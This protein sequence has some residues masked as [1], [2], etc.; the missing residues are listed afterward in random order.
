MGLLPISLNLETRHLN[1]CITICPVWFPDFSPSA[2][3]VAVDYLWSTTLV[4]C[5]DLGSLAFSLG[6]GGVV[7]S[8]PYMQVRKG[9]L[10][11]NTLACC[12]SMTHF[13]LTRCCPPSPLMLATIL[14][15]YPLCLKWAMLVLICCLHSLDR[16]L[17]SMA[18]ITASWGAATW[19]YGPSF[20]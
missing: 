17:M 19:L 11:K 14:S 2:S 9:D 16:C 3:T 18:P 4:A 6:G 15:A 7:L 12:L 1:T 20:S 8:A 13:L 5:R 10:L